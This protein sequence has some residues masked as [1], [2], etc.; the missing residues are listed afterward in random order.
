MLD[1]LVIDGGGFL[2]WGATAAGPGALGG[3][4]AVPKMQLGRVR[5]THRERRGIRRRWRIA[6]SLV[7][8]GTR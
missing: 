5:G 1:A 8:D 4:Y 7:C 3:R 6:R 2:I